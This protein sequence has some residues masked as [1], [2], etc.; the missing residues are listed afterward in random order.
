MEQAVCPEKITTLALANICPDVAATNY[1]QACLVSYLCPNCGKT[2]SSKQNLIA[3]QRTHS[4]EKSFACNFP[5]CGHTCATNVALN[6]HQKVHSK[7]AF[8]CNFPDCEKTFRWKAQLKTHERTHT[9][10]KIFTCNLCNKVFAYPYNLK[11]HNETLVHKNRCKR[12]LPQHN[13]LVNELG[14]LIA[15]KENQSNPREN[16]PFKEK[17]RARIVKSDQP[18]P[19]MIREDY[20]RT[21][22]TGSGTDNPYLL[23]TF[24]EA[25]RLPEIEQQDLLTN[26]FPLAPSY[27]ESNN[28]QDC[29]ERKKIYKCYVP[30]CTFE[31]AYNRN[32]TM[33]KRIHTGE[34]PFKR[35]LCNNSYVELIQNK[36][37]LPETAARENNS[38]DIFASKANDLPAKETFLPENS[39]EQEYLFD[40]YYP[41]SLG[42]Y[43]DTFQNLA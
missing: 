2:L 38:N 14:A 8:K 43:D 35:A 21:T 20:P 36:L 27:N 17:K 11:R 19:E 28:Q 34:K 30:G 41:P 40:G 4:K 22:T 15:F 24:S 16:A 1:Q 23:E 6:N 29:L 18:L 39:A 26:L 7:L 37:V 25:N 12:D 5:D 13:T 42:D 9:D 31:S 32:L 10:E 3:H 33:H